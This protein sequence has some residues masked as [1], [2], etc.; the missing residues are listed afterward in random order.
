MSL[1]MHI[2]LVATKR[3]TLLLLIADWH[4]P[5]VRKYHH[6]FSSYSIFLDRLFG[7]PSI[8]KSIARQP[9]GG[10]KIS[11][12][13]GDTPGVTPPVEV[14][15]IAFGTGSDVDLYRELIENHHYAM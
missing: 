2:G 10:P 7:L 15:F 6:A 4:D 5:R 12:V 13:C 1:Y 9:F 8:S 11:F 14:P 3:E